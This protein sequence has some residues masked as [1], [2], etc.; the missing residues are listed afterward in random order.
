MMRGFAGAVVNNLY[1]MN[2][3]ATK[4]YMLIIAGL[5]ATYFITGNEGV[6]AWSAFAVLMAIPMAALEN[7]MTPFTTNWTAFENVWGISPGTMVLSR[8]AT[9]I[10]LSIVCIGL[11]IAIPIFDIAD[12]FGN[13]SMAVVVLMVQ[14]TCIVYYPLL[15]LLNPKK[16]GLSIIL[17]FVS[18]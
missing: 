18:I 7:A 16:D 11:W 4:L 12:P 9:V 8:Y 3:K 14:F 5:L 13:M 6:L 15:Y 10:G 1:L 17:L 2:T